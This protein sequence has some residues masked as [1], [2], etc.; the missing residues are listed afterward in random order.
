MRPFV[1]GLL[2]VCSATEEDVCAQQKNPCTEYVLPH[3]RSLAAPALLQMKRR[4][5]AHFVHMQATGASRLD[6]LNESENDDFIVQHHGRES[7]RFEHFSAHR[8]TTG[9]QSHHDFLA[10]VNDAKDMTS[11]E[12]KIAKVEMEPVQLGGDSPLGGDVPLGGDY[13]A[14]DG[15]MPFTNMSMK[16]MNDMSKA[17][18]QLVAWLL[19]GNMVIIL[20]VCIWQAFSP[21][22]KNNIAAAELTKMSSDEQV[23]RSPQITSLAQLTALAQAPLLDATLNAPASN[24]QSQTPDGGAPHTLPPAGIDTDIVKF[25]SSTSTHTGEDARRRSSSRNSR[26][27]TRKRSKPRSKVDE[28]P[29]EDSRCLRTVDALCT[30]STGRQSSIPPRKGFF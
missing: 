14:K 10:E 1:I 20:V 5:P 23:T 25:V 24:N 3:D 17:I 7:S 19:F 21:R 15:R 26:A 12:I 18:M 16:E 27:D 11:P 13:K 22:R 30:P 6:S 8:E 29:K 28:T 9:A 4:A 2:A